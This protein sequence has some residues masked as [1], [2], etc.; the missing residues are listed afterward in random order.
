MTEIDFQKMQ[1]RGESPVI[2][3]IYYYCKADHHSLKVKTGTIYPNEDGSSTIFY[4]DPEGYSETFYGIVSLAQAYIGGTLEDNQGFYAD[5][6]FIYPDGNTN[7]TRISPG[8][9]IYASSF[10]INV[11]KW[12]MG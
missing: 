12:I 2:Q 10:G 3:S 8:T 11:I 9:T 1:E 6:T 7:T 4:C 5:V